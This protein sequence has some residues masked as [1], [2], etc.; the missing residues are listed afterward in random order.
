M[1]EITGEE[2]DSTQEDGQQ[3]HSEDMTEDGRY[4]PY[5]GGI[6]G[7]FENSGVMK[8][9]RG[10][11]PVEGKRIG[12]PLVGTWNLDVSSERGDRKQR[13][14]VFPDMSGLL[15]A[16]PIKK[17]QLQDG[18]VSFKISLEFGDRTLELDFQGKLDESS[19][20]GEITTSR[21]TQKVTGKKVIRRSR[22]GRQTSTI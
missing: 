7:W 13:L 4:I 8:S 18:K 1:T 22:R 15:G 12:A 10:E 20:T 5:G 9:E 19:L 6:M 21:G 2:V 16:T 14:R 3:N 11:T 17:I